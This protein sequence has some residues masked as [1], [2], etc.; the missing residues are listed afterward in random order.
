MSAVS[1]ILICLLHIANLYG[2]L[3]VKNVLSIISVFQLLYKDNK[4]FNKYTSLS[5][6][7][8]LY[9]FFCPIFLTESFQPKR[10]KGDFLSLKYAFLV[11]L[12]R[13]DML[14]GFRC[15]MERCPRE[16]DVSC[17]RSSLLTLG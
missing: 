10:A 2:Q 17:S 13:V 8:T 16:V 9:V 1:L 3:R 6:A 5:G 12:V 11:V 4:F 15:M 7:Y 14:D